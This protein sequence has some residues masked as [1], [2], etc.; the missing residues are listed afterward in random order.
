MVSKRAV[1]ALRPHQKS[2]FVIPT[3]VELSSYSFISLDFQLI[4]LRE[5]FT[6]SSNITT[7]YPYYSKGAVTKPVKTTVLR[8]DSVWPDSPFGSK[9]LRQF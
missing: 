7:I 3:L 6:S 5:D 1:F 9:L 4:G 8:Y 2:S